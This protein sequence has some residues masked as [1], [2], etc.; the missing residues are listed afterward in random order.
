MYEGQGFDSPH[1]HQKDMILRT[2]TKSLSRLTPVEYRACYSLNMRGNGCMRYALQ[3]HRA[4]DDC[5]AIMIWHGGVLA[6]WAL[7]VPTRKQS[8]WAWST[9]HAK[10]VSKYQAQFYVRKSMRGRGLAHRLMRQVLKMD[11]RPHVIP[12]SEASGGFFSSYNVST[13]RHRREYMK[14]K[15]RAA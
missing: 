6:A 3:E 15:S 2:T 8:V 5:Y 11:P 10:R 4:D 13:E 14:K 1:F 12:H 7:L 9:D